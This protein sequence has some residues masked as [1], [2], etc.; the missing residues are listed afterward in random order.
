MTTMEPVER[1]RRLKTLREA[2]GYKQRQV[3]A[4][5]DIDGR[6]VSEWER[7][8]SSPDR[9]KLV[10]LDEMYAADGEVLAMFDVSPTSQ[11][12]VRVAEL[13]RQVDQLAQLVDFLMK[14]VEAD[15]HDDPD[16]GA[17]RSDSSS[18]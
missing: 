3:G 4:W 9:R 2:A 5:F 6:A 13:E 7:G 17:T 10:R 14:D 15:E 11:L 8:K 1:G 16:H 12:D 18:A